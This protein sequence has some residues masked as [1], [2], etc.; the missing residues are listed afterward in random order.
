MQILCQQG[1]S[2]GVNKGFQFVSTKALDC[3]K[4]HVIGRIFCYSLI[5]FVAQVQALLVI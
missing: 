5:C 2:V 3:G 1:L 4:E